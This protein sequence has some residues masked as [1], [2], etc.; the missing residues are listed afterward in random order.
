MTTTIITNSGTF[1]FDVVLTE[2]H[3]SPLRVSENPVESGSQIADNAVLLPRPLEISGIMVDYNPDD[4]PFN[5]IAD[6][7]NIRE[8]DFINSVPIPAKLK[9]ITDQTVNYINR[10]LDLIASSASQ[11]VGGESGQRALAPWI[12]DLLPVDVSNLSV[13]DKRISDAYAALRGIQQTA[14]PVQVVTDTAIYDSVLLL[15]VRVRIT[16]EKAAI[17][18][19]PCKE[20][21]IVSTQTAGGVNVPNNIAK[22]KTSGRTAAQTSAPVNKGESTPKAVTPDEVAPGVMPQAGAVVG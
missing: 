18:S 1:E 17:F 13:S 11:L 19:I 9:G 14:V 7:Y 21:F 2:S 5:K 4:T 12:P 10:S 6:E 22:D 3:S 15:D 16:K 8:P 20:I